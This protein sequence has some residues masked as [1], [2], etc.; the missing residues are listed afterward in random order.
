MFGGVGEMRIVFLHGESVHICPEGYK[1]V[2][3]LGLS[4]SPKIND[5]SCGPMPLPTILT[6]ALLFNAK[7]EKHVFDFGVRLILC[8]RDFRMRM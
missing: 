1:V 5:E 4:F 8:K 2:F 7:G 6:D 3:S